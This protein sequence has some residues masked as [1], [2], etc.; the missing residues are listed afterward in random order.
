MP[1]RQQHLPCAAE[2]DDRGVCPACAAAV[3]PAEI[4]V[5]PGPGLSLEAEPTDPVGIALRA[6]HRMMTPLP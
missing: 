2:L 5:R 6:P 3:S 1:L 4:E